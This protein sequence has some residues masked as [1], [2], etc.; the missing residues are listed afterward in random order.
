MHRSGVHPLAAFLLGIVVGSAGTYYVTQPTGTTP[1]ATKAPHSVVITPR[2]AALAA[3]DTLTICSFNIQ[4]LGQ[5]ED[6]DAEGLADIVRDY[7]IVVVQ[8]LIAPPYPGKFPDGTDYVPDP[9]AARFFDAMKALG[10]DYMLSEED[11][12]T[13]AK[14]HL[15]TSATEWWVV[16]YR[17]ERIGPAAD[18]PR[19]FLADDRSNHPDYERVPYAFPFRT[20]DKNCD[21]VL[22]SVHLKPDPGPA[23]RARRKHELATIAAWIHTKDQSEKDFIILGDMNIEDAKELADAT[24]VGFLSLNDECRATNTNVK[25]PKP[26][27]HVL[28]QPSFST[29]VDHEFDLVVVNLI[30]AMRPRWLGPGAFPGDPY[31]H[32]AFRRFYSDHHPVVFRLKIPSADDD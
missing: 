15:N 2:K 7:D 10:F 31:E 9:Q 24:P 13:G 6:R 19:T 18:L 25:G 29:E 12:G 4:F 14:I 26:Y 5:S 32:D 11:T 22:I 1:D 23:S 20:L 28:F 3:G 16:F 8:E 17:P 27:D 21:F 30:E